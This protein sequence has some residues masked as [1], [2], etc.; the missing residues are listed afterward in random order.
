MSIA[1]RLSSFLN[2]FFD[3]LE[4]PVLLD[5]SF[6]SFTDECL[7]PVV[8]YVLAMQEAESSFRFFN[9]EWNQMS[10]YAK[11]TLYVAWTKC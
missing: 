11:R 1:G 6:N 7:Y 5:L 2:S 9:F 8:K 3:Q 10:N 4:E